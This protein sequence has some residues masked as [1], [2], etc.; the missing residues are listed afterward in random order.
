M[1]RDG[2][3]LERNV[4]LEH[5]NALRT[6]MQDGIIEIKELQKMKKY[7]KRKEEKAI[8]FYIKIFVNNPTAIWH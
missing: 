8:R 2:L 7:N 6:S 4:H 1:D 3:E 5:Q